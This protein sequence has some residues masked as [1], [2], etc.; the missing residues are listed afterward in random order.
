MDAV[1]YRNETKTLRLKDF[2]V[3][4]TLDAYRSKSEVSLKTLK[5]SLPTLSGMVGVLKRLRARG[6]V[7][8]GR[9][10]ELTEYGIQLLEYGRA[11]AKRPREEILAE[12]EHSDDGLERRAAQAVRRIDAFSLDENRALT[13]MFWWA[14]APASL[15]IGYWADCR[16]LGEEAAQQG[17]LT[18]LD[19]DGFYKLVLERM[20]HADMVDRSTIVSKAIEYHKRADYDI[21]VP[22][23]LIQAEG[24]ARDIVCYFYGTDEKANGEGFISWGQVVERISQRLGEPREHLR[25]F[26]AQE[27]LNRD[28][29]CHGRSLTYGN[30]WQSFISL[31]YL[32]SMVDR[33]SESINMPREA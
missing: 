17:V 10:I 4:L 2:E 26:D 16:E 1:T 25:A 3:L 28:D 27:R 6:Y 31:M 5:E 13:P 7:T 19:V 22:I 29:V 33:Y 14:N 21:S 20:S 18:R 32:Y 12:I 24:I 8:R 23:F 15:V 11:Q 9:P 30:R